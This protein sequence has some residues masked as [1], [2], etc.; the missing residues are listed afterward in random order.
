MQDP[1]SMM[2]N[3]GG[4]IAV[5]LDVDPK[6]EEEFN[7]W[8][9]FEHLQQVVG[10]NG[11]LS[12]RRYVADYLYPRFLALYE[13]VDESAEAA[14]LDMMTTPTPW[15]LR[16][17]PMYGENRKRNNYRRI[18]Y[19]INGTDPYG[20]VILLM[21]GDAVPGKA[22]EN[23]QWLKCNAGLA[24]NV[25]GC[26]SVRYYAA[27]SGSPTYLELYEFSNAAA[28]CSAQWYRFLTGE[29]RRPLASSLVNVIEQRYQ[30]IATPFV[31][32]GTSEKP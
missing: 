11:F 26:I 31:R 10:L 29:A 27:V 22:S 3:A 8:Y 21:Q 7:A 19:A 14:L 6:H 17:R 24:L 16:I 28:P 30:A 20:A 12:G 32:E 9:K 13:T 15:S 2:A 1:A 25:P 5:W 18:A 23:E 4:L